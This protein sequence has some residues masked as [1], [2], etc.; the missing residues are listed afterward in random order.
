M[1][2]YVSN[3]LDCQTYNA[4]R[5][6]VSATYSLQ[7]GWIGIYSGTQPA[8]ADA[9]TTGTLLMAITNS[10]GTFS[11]GVY[12]TSDAD[13]IC[14]TQ[15]PGSPGAMTING[16]T[17]GTLG[18]GYYVTIS[19]TGN[20]SAKIFRIT[21]TGNGDEAIIEYL[22]GPNNTTV[23]TKNTFKTVTEVYASAATAAAVTVGYG[24]TNG[25]FL[26]LA[27][28]GAIGKHASQTWSG[29]GIADGTAGWF[30]FYGAATD[31]GGISTT[32]PR[33]DGRIATSGAELNLS[34]TSIV[35]G[36]SQT[37]SSFT[38]T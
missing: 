29:I 28:N 17:S 12:Q 10:A 16:T 9:A 20:E 36:A 33:I 1:A 37:I 21:G 3:G 38:I 7:G 13:G 31:A 18:V 25:L 23:S 2:F 15:T 27:A 32:L 35:T 34:N 14:L 4:I 11:P 26:A 24:I 22:Q 6:A 8:S 5:G 30:R 19:G